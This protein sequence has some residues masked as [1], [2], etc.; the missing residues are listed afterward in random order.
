VTHPVKAK[1]HE[2]RS[3]GNPAR[4]SPSLPASFEDTWPAVAESVPRARHAVIAHLREAATPDPPLSDVALAV[5]EAV[6][7]VV[8]HAYAGDAT[9]GS[10]RVGLG[11]TPE[12]I[13]LTV[14]DDGG[15]LVPRLDSPG[16]GLGLPL[17][18]HVADRFDTRTA[19]GE[20]TR[21]CVWFRR[22]PA[23]ATL[24]D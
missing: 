11:V 8:N 16:M 4:V 23:E 24:K 1:V 5:S 15:G 13:R 10:V 12:E 22:D 7:N 21:L 17:I 14:E 6:S 18:A 2:R 3:A 19:P 20:G 9:P